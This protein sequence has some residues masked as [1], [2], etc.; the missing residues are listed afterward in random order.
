MVCPIIGA[1]MLGLESGQVNESDTYVT[2]TPRYCALAVPA[3]RN[4]PQWVS[5]ALLRFALM[6]QRHPL[7]I[8][9]SACTGAQPVSLSLGY[10]AKPD[11]SEGT[12]DKLSAP[13]IL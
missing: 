6:R 4:K 9:Q 10:R 12:D 8:P 2:S 11:F 1:E 13:G 3:L 5:H 7:S